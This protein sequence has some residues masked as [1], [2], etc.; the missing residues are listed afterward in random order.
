VVPE[1][2]AHQREVL[3]SLGDERVLIYE[4]TSGW[5]PLCEFLSVPVPDIPFPRTNARARFRRH[6]SDLREQA[7]GTP[8]PSDSS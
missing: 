7:S 5:K 4:L 1:F 8:Y 2:A 6:Y 3:A